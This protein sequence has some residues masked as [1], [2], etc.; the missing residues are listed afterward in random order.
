MK[1]NLFT[2]KFNIFSQ[3]VPKM[4]QFYVKFKAFIKFL[5]LL[6]LKYKIYTFDKLI[7]KI[8]YCQGYCEDIQQLKFIKVNTVT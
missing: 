7:K 2:I 3:N 4:L 5:H 6:I 8:N 1:I